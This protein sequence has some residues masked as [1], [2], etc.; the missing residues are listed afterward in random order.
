MFALAT[1]TPRVYI[2]ALSPGQVPQAE[3]LRPPRYESECGTFTFLA[4]R[5]DL[6]FLKFIEVFLH[7]VAAETSAF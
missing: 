7:Q 5:F 6:P 3:L 1:R 2:K 4:T